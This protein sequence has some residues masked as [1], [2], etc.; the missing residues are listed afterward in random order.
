[1]LKDLEKDFSYYLG[2]KRP[3]GLG[4]TIE[5]LMCVRLV[6]VEMFQ[7]LNKTNEINSKRIAK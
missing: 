3:L 7:K 6:D 5:L 2:L 4:R 1:M